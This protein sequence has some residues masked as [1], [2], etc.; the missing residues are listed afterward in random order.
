MRSLTNTHT[1]VSERE[2]RVNNLTWPHT[3][4]TSIWDPSRSIFPKNVFGDTICLRIS[5]VGWSVCRLSGLFLPT[6]CPSQGYIYQCHFVGPLPAVQATLGGAEPQLDDFT[7]GDKVALVLPSAEWRR[8]QRTTA[9]SVSA[10]KGWVWRGSRL[11]GQMT[12]ESLFTKHRNHGPPNSE[13]NRVPWWA[14]RRFPCYPSQS[15]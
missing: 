13:L 4:A 1:C 12:R 7:Q 8:P 6:G 9:F 15:L 5:V 14:L 3:T 11:E 2:Y 10:N